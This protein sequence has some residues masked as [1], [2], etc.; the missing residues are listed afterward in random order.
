MHPVPHALC[1]QLQSTA[2]RLQVL[3]VCDSSADA[4]F[5]AIDLLSQA[6][7]GVDSQV[8]LVAI[9]LSGMFLLCIVWLS[10]SKRIVFSLASCTVCHYRV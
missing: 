3:V 10:T 9:D 6:E 8:V 4:E 1:G 5:V 2:Y 7:H